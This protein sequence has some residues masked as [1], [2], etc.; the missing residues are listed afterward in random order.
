MAMGFRLFGPIQI[1]IIAA[2][3]GLAAWLSWFGRRNPTAGARN[4]GRAWRLSTGK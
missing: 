3:L 4:P 2:I 1:A